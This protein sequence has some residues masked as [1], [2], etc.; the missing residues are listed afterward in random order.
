M[1]AATS[2]IFGSHT[3]LLVDLLLQLVDL[4]AQLGG[5]LV[6]LHVGRL[7]LVQAQ[8][9]DLLLQLAHPVVGI[10]CASASA[11]RPGRSGRRLFGRLRSVIPIESSAAAAM[12]RR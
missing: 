11:P 10:V 6:V 9:F 12:V 8:L 5:A 1:L 2:A 4:V 7:F 3:L